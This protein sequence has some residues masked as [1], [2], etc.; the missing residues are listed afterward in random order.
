MEEKLESSEDS[1]EKSHRDRS[2]ECYEDAD[3]EE[4]YEEESYCVFNKVYKKVHDYSC[5]GRCSKKVKNVFVEECLMGC[6]EGKCIDSFPFECSSNYDCGFN[7]FT[8]ERYCVENNVNQY[9]IN[10]TCENPDSE[11]SKCKMN[12]EEKLVDECVIPLSCYKG[13]CAE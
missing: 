3:C 5:D 12:I 4:D 9:F 13:M 6:S 10:W 11:N 2:V 7:D 8:G 1:D